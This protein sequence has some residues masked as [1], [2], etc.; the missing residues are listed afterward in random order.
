MV[1][2]AGVKAGLGSNKSSPTLLHK[3]RELVKEV[4]KKPR[5]VAFLLSRD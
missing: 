5:Y 4:L 2:I 3:R 1:K